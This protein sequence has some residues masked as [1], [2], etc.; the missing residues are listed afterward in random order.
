VFWGAAYLKIPFAFKGFKF[1]LHSGTS[2]SLFAFS[3]A[4]YSVFERAVLILF[5]L[6]AADYNFIQPG[7]ISYY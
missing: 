6:P 5:C 2:L 4:A 1:F 3:L 7:S